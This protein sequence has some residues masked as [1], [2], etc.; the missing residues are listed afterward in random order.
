[1]EVSRPPL[2][3]LSITSSTLSYNPDYNHQALIP[4]AEAGLILGASNLN[5]NSEPNSIRPYASKAY[6]EVL[7]LRLL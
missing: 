2:S 1:M 3:Q 5:Y 7:K 6:N 4:I